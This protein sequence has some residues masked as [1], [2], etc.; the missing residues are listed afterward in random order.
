VP[1]EQVTLAYADG[2]ILGNCDVDADRWH[3]TGRGSGSSDVPPGQPLTRTLPAGPFTFR[4]Y[5]RRGPGTAAQNPRLDLI[6]LTE[7][8]TRM[9]TDDDARQ[10]LGR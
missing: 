6:C 8:P 5:A 1:G 3:W 10:R 7:D 4:I 9:P 2:Q